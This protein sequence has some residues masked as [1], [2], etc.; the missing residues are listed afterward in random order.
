MGRSPQ[1]PFS[2]VLDSMSTAPPH[3]ASTRVEMVNSEPK[4][5]MAI[6]VITQDQLPAQSPAKPLRLDSVIKQL[7]DSFEL[8]RRFVRLVKLWAGNNDLADQHQ[9][10]IPS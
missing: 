6:F 10:C 9:G 1:C 2:K 7:C 4:V 5:V 8:S 3:T